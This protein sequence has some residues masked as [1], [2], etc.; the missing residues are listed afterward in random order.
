VP[1]NTS[2]HLLRPE[3]PAWADLLREVHAFLAEDESTAGPHP[4][5][6]VSKE[7]VT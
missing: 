7:P 6:A 3:E 2:N 5:H 1:L 4:V